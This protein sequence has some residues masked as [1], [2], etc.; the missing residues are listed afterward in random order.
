MNRTNDDNTND[1]RVDVLAS[2][3]KVLPSLRISHFFQ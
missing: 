3:L 2:E 1:G